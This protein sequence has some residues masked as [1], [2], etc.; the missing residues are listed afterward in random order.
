MLQIKPEELQA[1]NDLKKEATDIVYALGEL[2]Y[3]KTVLD[4]QIA[5]QKKKVESV[6]TREISMFNELEA[7]YG[8]VSINLETGEYS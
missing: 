5:D 1:I 3:Q 7:A 8:R 6:K 4:L 2:E